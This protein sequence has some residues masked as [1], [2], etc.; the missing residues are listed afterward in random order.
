MLQE[1]YEQQ[2]LL[3]E[4]AD[5]QLQYE[6]ERREQQQR[7]IRDLRDTLRN[8]KRDKD[9]FREEFRRLRERLD[10]QAE[11]LRRAEQR[12]EDERRAAARKIDEQREILRRAEERVEE[13]RREA[14]R[15]V[16]LAQSDALAAAVQNGQRL[17]VQTEA[18]G[19]LNVGI[20][21]PKSK[22]ATQPAAQGAINWLTSQT[23]GSRAQTAGQPTINPNQV[24]GGN[25]LDAG[26]QVPATQVSSTPAHTPAHNTA[27]QTNYRPRQPITSTQ[28]E[29][30]PNHPLPRTPQLVLFLVLTEVTSQRYFPLWEN[31]QNK[32]TIC[33]TA[34]SFSIVKTAMPQT[35]E[36]IQYIQNRLMVRISW[37]LS[38]CTRTSSLQTHGIEKQQLAT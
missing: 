8:E 28:T 2:R 5:M 17:T 30:F 12:I 33:V 31:S 13:E 24:D 1:K 20:S 27:P 18:A 10:E 14:A 34:A 38:Q 4:Q 16:G 9:E 22:A 29:Y 25:Q 7:E 11:D 15:Q 21:S 26:L 37:L 6:R 32:R 19:G 3:A 35:R 23:A 36:D